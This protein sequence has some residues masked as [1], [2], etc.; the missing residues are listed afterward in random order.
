MANL[1]AIRIQVSIQP[2]D[3]SSGGVNLTEEFKVS[4]VE[5]ME[6]CKILGQFHDLAVK[7][8]RERGVPK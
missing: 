1:L 5:F 8:E 3:Y 2:Q 7:I 6:V 4:Q